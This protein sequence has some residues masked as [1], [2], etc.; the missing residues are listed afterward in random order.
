M[1][2]GTPKQY[3]LRRSLITVLARWIHR[4]PDL[5]QAINEFSAFTADQLAGFSGI[6]AASSFLLKSSELFLFDS[7]FS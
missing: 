5:I 3:Y 7:C 4:R 2:T 6:F 1:R